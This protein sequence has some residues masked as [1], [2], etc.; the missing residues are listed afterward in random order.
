VSSPGP[1]ELHE[2]ACQFLDFGATAAHALLPIQ[3]TRDQWTLDRCV[4]CEQR[5][6]ALDVFH[7]FQSVN[8]LLYLEGVD[9][10]GRIQSRALRSGFH[11]IH[12]PQEARHPED[13]RRARNVTD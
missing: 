8:D 5:V 9:R 11:G 7:G 6:E 13:T 3:E 4:F 12:E 2:R 1:T 10:L